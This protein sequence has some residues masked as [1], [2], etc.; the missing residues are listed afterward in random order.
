MSDRTGYLDDLILE[1]RMLDVPGARIGQIV[2]EAENHLAESGEAPEVAFGSARSYARE[3]WAREDRPLPNA[4]DTR[5][6]FAM[7][8]SGMTASTWAV[9]LVSFVLTALG[10]SALL[11]GVLAAVFG[12][13]TLLGLP[14]W[15]LIVGGALMLAAYFLGARRLADPIVDPRTGQQ[16]GFDRH[17]HRKSEDQRRRNGEIR[18]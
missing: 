11:N 4:V 7:L 2:A 17:G 13:S 6:P 15:V 5:N 10:A 9:M 14:A 3:L 1:L 8:V 16:V 18:R 12:S